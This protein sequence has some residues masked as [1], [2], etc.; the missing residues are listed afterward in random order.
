VGVEPFEP[1]SAHNPCL[2][3][4]NPKSAGRIIRVKPANSARGIAA[5]NIRRIPCRLKTERV[6]LARCVRMN[7]IT[8]QHTHTHLGQV[9]VMGPS[10]GRANSET[11]QNLVN[12]CRLSDGEDCRTSHS[13]TTFAYMWISNDAKSG[14]LLHMF[15]ASKN[16]NEDCA[17]RKAECITRQK[18]RCIVW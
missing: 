5:A 15:T 11:A 12:Y 10:G 13:Y 18:S 7:V 8:P 6:I 3:A 2:E 4:N 17:T 16:V 1:F 9:K 14:E